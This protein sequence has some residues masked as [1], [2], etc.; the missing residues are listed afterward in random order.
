MRVAPVPLPVPLPVPVLL[1]RVPAPHVAL[2]VD[3]RIAHVAASPN[4]DVIAFATRDRVWV[5]RDG[6]ASFDP[7]LEGK[8]EISEL[9][10]DA[11]G[12]VYAKRPDALGMQEEG[13]RTHWIPIPPL[14][15]RL[16]DADGGLFLGEQWDEGV[17]MDAIDGLAWINLLEGAQWSVIAGKIVTEGEARVIVYRS[18]PEL[19]LIANH[20]EHDRIAWRGHGYPPCAALVG[21]DQA[22]IV[23]RAQ[24]SQLL[25]IDNQGKAARVPIDLDLDAD[26]VTCTIAGN[27]HATYATFSV[28]G[29][30]PRLYG[31]SFVTRDAT[32]LGGDPIDLRAVDDRG[33]ALGLRDGN[34]VRR[35]DDGSFELL[36]RG[37]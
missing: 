10:V 31:L 13:M 22:W 17:V 14:D 15:G 2:H 18:A 6:G 29:G 8:G 16:L 7:E 27:D 37:R 28:D 19:H 12:V 34:L 26:R 20:E 4:R 30:A 33:R 3:G 21:D 35:A 23:D 9:F 1:A 5:S 25:A 11:G 36:A 32:Y 24:P